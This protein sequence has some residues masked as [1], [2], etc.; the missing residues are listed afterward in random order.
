[1]QSRATEKGMPDRTPPEHPCPVG[2]QRFN[3]QPPWEDPVMPGRKSTAAKSRIKSL[4]PK[5]VNPKHGEAL[6]GGLEGAAN[7][8]KVR[9]DLTTAQINKLG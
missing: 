1:V 7:L 3:A 6:G 2:D 4:R 8:K 5:A 9:H